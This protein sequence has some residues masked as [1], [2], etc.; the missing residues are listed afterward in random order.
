MAIIARS[1]LAIWPV[2]LLCGITSF[3]WFGWP[4]RRTLLLSLLVG[5]ALGSH[6]FFADLAVEEKWQATT[7]RAASPPEVWH[8]THVTIATAFVMGLPA[9]AARCVRLFQKKPSTPSP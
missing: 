9:L 2:S 4:Q 1:L 8:L 7:G 3:A 6:I 5:L